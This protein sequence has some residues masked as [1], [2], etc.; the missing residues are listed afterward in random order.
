MPDRFPD[1]CSFTAR[2]NNAMAKAAPRAAPTVNPAPTILQA[3]TI[4][5]DALGLSVIVQDKPKKPLASTTDDRKRQQLEDFGW[6]TSQPG[7]CNHLRGNWVAISEHQIVATG[8]D[9]K[10]VRAGAAAKLSIPKKDVLVVPI[11]VPGS[12]ESWAATCQRLDIDVDMATLS[13]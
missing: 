2:R 8:P 3:L 13:P 11:Q 10:A 12:E 1:V 6:L 9:E 7:L 4:I 5:G